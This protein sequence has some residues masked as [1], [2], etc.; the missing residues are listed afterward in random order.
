MTFGV[1]H[2]DAQQRN[3]LHLHSNCGEYLYV[4][5]GSCEHRIGDT[6][7][8]L[9]AG[10]LV[11]IPAG[12]SHMARTLEESMQAVIVYNSGTRDFTVV[13]EQ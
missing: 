11:R 12:V 1:V 8:T 2:V 9:K 5:S 13:K 6:W 4:L 7:V 10:D 3:P